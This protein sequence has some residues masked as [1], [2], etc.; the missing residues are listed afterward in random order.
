MTSAMMKR[1]TVVALAMFV[2]ASTARESFAGLVVR[3]LTPVAAQTSAVFHGTSIGNAVS[4]TFAYNPLTPTSPMPA[5]GFSGS[6]AVHFGGAS[7]TDVFASYNFTGGP[8]THH[9][10]AQSFFVDLYGRSDSCCTD[11]DNNIDVQVFSG[12]VTGTLLGTITGASIGATF[13]TRVNLGSV[14]PT[15]ALFDAIRIVGHD[16]EAAAGNNFTLMEI[17]A[18]QVTI[19]EPATAA[20]ALMGV[21]GLMARR[22]RLA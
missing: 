14:I 17:R 3:Q 9:G 20:L 11:R 6:A 15:G 19:P 4:D 18:A 1:M 5:T 13:H 2:M 21:A 22:R 8:L 10:P 7:N 16:S 12:G